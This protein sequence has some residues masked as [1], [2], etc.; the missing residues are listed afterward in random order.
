MNFSKGFIINPDRFR[1]PSYA[2]SPFTTESL[3]IINDILNNRSNVGGSVTMQFFGENFRFTASGKEAISM[4]L[5]FYNF[6]HED[7]VLILTSS[8]NKYVSSCVTSEI[9]KFCHWSRE[10]SEKTKLIFVIHEFGKIHPDLEKIRDYGLPI[11]EDLAMS[12][13]SNNST[14]SA[15]RIGDFAIY[16]LPKFFP[17]QFGGVL[18][19]TNADFIGD[20]SNRSDEKL[21]YLQTIAE[22][23]LNQKEEICTARVD[24]YLYLES[25]LKKLGFESRLRP[26]Q[27]EIPSVYMFTDK[28]TD[29]DGMKVFMQ[30]NGVECSKFYGENSFFVPVHQNLSTTDLD[31]II[32]LIEY[33]KNNEIK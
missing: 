10:F 23:Y 22:Y 29:F 31:F 17:V 19:S 7:E 13:F 26:T 1:V 9:E 15:G 8:G 32:N 25:N 30:N 14:N 2:I 5:S 18:K 33:F 6:C 12:M 27:E 24:N 20:G 11:I 21:C 3:T 28:N 16:S 4:A